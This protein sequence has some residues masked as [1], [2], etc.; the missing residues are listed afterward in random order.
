MEPCLIANEEGYVQVLN[1]KKKRCT[2]FIGYQSSNLLAGK[3][4]AENSTIGL[5]TSNTTDAPHSQELQRL[6]DYHVS[7][8]SANPQSE[9]RNRIANLEA[10]LVQLKRRQVRT[11]N[12]SV[13]KRQDVINGTIDVADFRSHFQTECDN[14]LGQLHSNVNFTWSWQPTSTE[15]QAAELFSELLLVRER[16]RVSL[17]RLRQGLLFRNSRDTIPSAAYKHL[18]NFEA[19]ALQRELAFNVLARST[20]AEHYLT[21]YAAVSDKIEQIRQQYPQIDQ[22]ISDSN[23]QQLLRASHKASSNSRLWLDRNSNTLGLRQSDAHPT[24]KPLISPRNQHIPHGTTLATH[25]ARVNP[26]TE[27]IERTYAEVTAGTRSS[28]HA[29]RQVERNC[30]ERG[31]TSQARPLLVKV[32]DEN[33]P[34]PHRAAQAVTLPKETVTFAAPFPQRK[35]VNSVE[36]PVNRTRVTQ[37]SSR[38]YNP[39]CHQPIRS[40]AFRQRDRD[41][42]Q[43]SYYN[44]QSLH[45]LSNRS[46]FAQPRHDQLGFRELRHVEHAAEYVPEFTGKP[47]KFYGRPRYSGRWQDR[48]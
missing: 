22:L 33:Q 31:S 1:R 29:N 5:G 11:D 10:E 3:V 7:V 28:V 43:Y 36:T 8:P 34:Q 46:H 24:T 6:A 15:S 47:K 40:H 13:T 37:N 9:L 39:N 26:T 48:Y 19:V 23:W 12:P 45:H 17:T 21:L 38:I 20:V 4:L 42:R 2:K 44:N 32:N 25:T 30:G 16:L 18:T 14:I 41:F 35:F 27:P